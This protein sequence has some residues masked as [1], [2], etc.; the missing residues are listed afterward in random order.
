MLFLP[1]PETALVNLIAQIHGG[2]KSANARQT[3]RNELNFSARLWKSTGPSHEWNCVQDLR[4]STSRQARNR[5]K[6]WTGRALPSPRLSRSMRPRKSRGSHHSTSLRS[7]SSCKRRRDKGVSYRRPHSRDYSGVEAEDG[8]PN[9]HRPVA[10][11][12]VHH[13]F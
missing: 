10:D 9:N 1:K 6:T 11:S 2:R 4:G 5:I 8:A 13:R 3:V 7:H 12:V